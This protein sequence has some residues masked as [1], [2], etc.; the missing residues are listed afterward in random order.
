MTWEENGCD[1]SGARVACSS[2]AKS[3]PVMNDPINLKAD[4]LVDILKSQAV[5][6][7]RLTGA[8]RNKGWNACMYHIILRLHNKQA[9]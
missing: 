5:T 7:A 3:M 4:T 8:R 6:P 1:V 2:M 9:V